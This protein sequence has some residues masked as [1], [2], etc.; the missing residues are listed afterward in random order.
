MVALKLRRSIVT[1]R[2]AAQR[3]RNAV[4]ALK[5][6]SPASSAVKA[7]TLRHHRNEGFQG[8]DKGN[9]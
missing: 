4:V 6:P 8:S 5:L 2:M 7:W 9:R 3:S 1:S